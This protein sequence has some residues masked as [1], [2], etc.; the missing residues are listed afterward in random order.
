MLPS[1]SPSYY[2]T[3][4]P[5]A[6]LSPTNALKKSAILDFMLPFDTLLDSESIATFEETLEEF[7]RDELSNNSEGTKVKYFNVTVVSQRVVASDEEFSDEEVYNAETEPEPVRRVKPEP[8]RRRSLEEMSLIVSVLIDAIVSPITPTT[9]IDFQREVTKAVTQ[10]S[11]R[12]FG[13]LFGTEAFEEL[14]PTDQSEESNNP[15]ESTDVNNTVAIATTSA[16]S[17][18][19]GSIAL[20]FFVIRRRRVA[21]SDYIV[22]KDVVPPSDA[23]LGSP[24]LDYANYDDDDVVSSLGDDEMITDAERD[25]KVEIDDGADKWSLD[26]AFPLQR[27]EGLGMPHSHLTDSDDDATDDEVWKDATAF[28]TDEK[29]CEN[30]DTPSSR[31]LNSFE[32]K[33]PVNDE[34]FVESTKPQ[35]D[36]QPKS[37]LKSVLNFSCFADNTFKEQEDLVKRS[38][39]GS[40]SRLYEVRVPPGPLGI[41]VDNSPSGGTVIAEVKA[42]SPLKHMVSVG[43]KI[44]MLDDVDTSKKSAVALGQWIMKKPYKEEQVL[45]VMAKEERGANTCDDM[46]D[47]S[48]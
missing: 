26:D 48:V 45:I 30:N 41:I 39:F 12:F 20:I 22:Q 15:L 18:V 17:V 47:M 7:L 1:S 27:S 42:T 9:E 28:A 2:P 25:S 44:V 46:E 16:C 6:S 21:E 24:P 3:N 40:N 29:A 43:D 38:S 37:M 31:V 13:Q 36:P 11:A 35:S 32:E 14:D 5:S 10:D 8:V 19:L 34:V 33:H 4:I 23:G